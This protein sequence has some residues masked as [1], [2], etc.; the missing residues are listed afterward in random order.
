MLRSHR[1]AVDLFVRP[2]IKSEEGIVQNNF[3]DGRNVF[4]V[5]RHSH[6]P[7]GRDVLDEISD[8]VVRRHRYVESV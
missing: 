2:T 8:R 3:E 7:S 5:E 4:G 1:Q 6:I